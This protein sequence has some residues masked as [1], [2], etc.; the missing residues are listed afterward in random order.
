MS[1]YILAL[2]SK[3]ELFMWV[4]VATELL[5]SSHRSG[6]DT[7]RQSGSVAVQRLLMAAA[8]TGEEEGCRVC[9][10]WWLS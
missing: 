7:L 10:R 8:Q 6:E 4:Y 9:I 5:D 2:W 1:L 3:C